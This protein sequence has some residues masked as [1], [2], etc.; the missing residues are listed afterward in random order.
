MDIKKLQAILMSK[1]IRVAD[2]DPVFTLIALNEAALLQIIASI[3]AEVIAL[4]VAADK[5]MQR[6]GAETMAGLATEVAKIAHR[7]ADDSAIAERHKAFYLAA[8]LLSLASTL[9]FAVGILLGAQIVSWVA[10]GAL[11]LLVGLVGGIC[12]TI[13][14]QQKIEEEEK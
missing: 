1:G 11:S 10:L 3:R 6:A 5:Q 9:F 13:F 12:L 4:P 8:G 14:L 7:I 2:D